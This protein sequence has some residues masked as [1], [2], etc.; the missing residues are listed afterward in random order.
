MITITVSI[1]TASHV[2][3]T[4]VRVQ[5]DINSTE[6]ELLRMARYRAARKVFG[7]AEFVESDSAPHEGTIWALENGVYYAHP[8]KM[9][10]ERTFS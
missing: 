1:W 6:P 10:A 5:P 3:L 2:E 9:V 8:V 7:E 4:R